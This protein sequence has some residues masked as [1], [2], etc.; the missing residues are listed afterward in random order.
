MRASPEYQYVGLEEDMADMRNEVPEG[1][2]LSMAMN[3]KAMYNFTS[4]T[5]EQ[6]DDIIERSR[7]VKSKQEM[8]RLIDSIASDRVTFL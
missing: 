8:E 3:E 2:V 5:A 6:R 1:L 4:M 7:Q